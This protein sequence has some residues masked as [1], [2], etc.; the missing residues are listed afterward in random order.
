MDVQLID[1]DHPSET[2]KFPK[3]RFEVY[4]VG[5]RRGGRATRRKRASGSVR[6]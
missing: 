5:P 2:R 3:G 1:L 4:Q 6:E